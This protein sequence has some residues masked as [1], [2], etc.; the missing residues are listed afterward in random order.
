MPEIIP[1]SKAVEQVVLNIQKCIHD[2]PERPSVW[3]CCIHYTD[4]EE[5][6]ERKPRD[7]GMQLRNTLIKLLLHITVPVKLHSIKMAIDTTL[8]L[9]NIY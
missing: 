1:F 8:I 4:S 5:L 9:T 6:D 3:N 2:F 7:T